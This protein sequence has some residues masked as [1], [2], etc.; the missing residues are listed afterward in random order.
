MK[1]PNTRI[2]VGYS[3]RY[4]DFAYNKENVVQPDHE[5][6]PTWDDIKRGENPVLE[7]CLDYKEE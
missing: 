6:I 7:W 4:Y 3:V 1:L 2:L 5:V